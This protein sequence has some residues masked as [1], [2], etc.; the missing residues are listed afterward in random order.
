MSGITPSELLI[1]KLSEM[2][3]YYEA[4]DYH[5]R[6]KTALKAWE[7]RRGFPFDAEADET[8]WDRAWTVAEEIALEVGIPA[9]DFITY[10]QDYELWVRN[11][12]ESQWLDEE[13][14][15]HEALKNGAL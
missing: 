6:F 14:S 10:S 2:T 5:T 11:R 1:A 15:N 12:T 13:S 8:Q 9:R 4:G 3:T 7:L